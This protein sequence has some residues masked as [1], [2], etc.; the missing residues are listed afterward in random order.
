MSPEPDLSVLPSAAPDA[1]DLPMW[2]GCRRGELLIHRCDLCGRV[3]WPSWNCT[4]HGGASMSW[5][6]AAGTGTLHTFTVYH[7]SYSPAM[8]GR[9]PYVVA[10]V[11]LDE[12]PD[13][14]TS[15]VGVAP[16]EC[17]IG[18][19]VAVEFEDRPDG[20]SLPVFRPVG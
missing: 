16:D 3:S 1:L 12:G 18:M 15:I 11:R 4:E 8:Q 9:T 7:H 14:H 10:I 6:P 20:Y 13:M 2:E 17:R 5:V 19:R